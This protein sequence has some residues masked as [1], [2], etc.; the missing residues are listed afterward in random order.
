MK[1]EL[2]ILILLATLAISQ[3]SNASEPKSPAK[4]IKLI[5]NNWTS[6]IVLSKVTGD[7]FQS[8]GYTVEY[9][10]ASTEDQW[11]A[12]AHGVGHVQVEVWEGTMSDKFNRMLL[13]G[14]IIDAGT[15]LAK[16]REEWWY[17]KYV[18]SQCPGLPDWKA[19]KSCSEIFAQE[20]SGPIGVYYAGPWEK[21]DE[22]RIRALGL[23]FK[24][25]V[26]P[27]GDDLWVKLKEAFKEKRPIVLF[28]WTPNWVESRY[29][30]KFVEFPTYSPECETQPSWGLNKS[31]LHD[32]GNPKGGWLKKAAWSGME[33]TW[34]CAYKTLKNITFNNAQIASA[35]AFVDVDKLSYDEAAKRWLEDNS[36][37]WKSWIPM[38]CSQ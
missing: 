29:E 19:L 32:C 4:P 38:D 25:N 12:M 15:H 30:G 23:K 20:G 17:P 22:A 18:E 8:M 2:Q 33:A 26:L 21:P 35:S 24:V 10:A 7:I 11:G 34:N 5:T 13:E 1:I 31:Y 16:T 27:K 3:I 36:D 9:L 37:V 6:Q 14:G 28:N